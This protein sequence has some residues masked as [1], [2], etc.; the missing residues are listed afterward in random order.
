VGAVE[1]ELK[2]L[3]PDAATAARL[4]AVARLAGY[5]VGP[6]E[7]R[8]DR[9][10]FLDTA[11]RRLL[12]AG[13]YLRRRE[14]A[15]G[16]TLTLKGA[17]PAAALPGGVTP[18]AVAREEVSVAVD[19]AAPPTAL[20]PGP[21]AERVAALSG[22]RPLAPLAELRQERLAR[23]LRRDGREVAELSLDTVEVPAAGGR[24]GRRWREV[25]VELREGG[26]VADLAALDAELRGRWG[27]RPVPAAKVARALA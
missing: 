13:W 25:E 22:G 19:P 3:V 10:L 1:V 15:G 12:R 6:G 26:E 11:D 21:L 23:P 18:A 16:V 4:A 24:P 7:P 5:E 27:L 20:P 14:Q 9:D 8:H 17:A 2:Y